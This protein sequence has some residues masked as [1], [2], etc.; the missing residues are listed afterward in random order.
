M[1]RERVKKPPDNLIGIIGPTSDYDK[2]AVKH[3]SECL[4]R[5]LLHNGYLPLINPTIGSTPELFG[6]VFQQQTGA[7]VWC[8][9][10]PKPSGFPM[11]RGLNHSLCSHK[12]KI[13]C[14]TWAQQ[15]EVL[16]QHTR[17][18]ISLG[19]CTGSVW[20]MCLTKY[21]WKGMGKLFVLRELE[22]ES[23]PARLNQRLRVE[24]IFL[25]RL[26]NELR[27]DRGHPWASGDV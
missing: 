14:R 2:D 27:T 15:P 24:Y 21:Y 20:E 13:R 22:S 19:I 9:V 4:S 6:K 26:A 18:L 1:G 25:S 7:Q 11:Y 3:V 16:V 12:N 8:L 17:C 10:Y 23:L 5:I